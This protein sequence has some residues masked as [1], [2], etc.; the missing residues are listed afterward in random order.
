MRDA[1]KV[2][3]DPEKALVAQQRSKEILKVIEAAKAR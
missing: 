2:R 1:L 3:L